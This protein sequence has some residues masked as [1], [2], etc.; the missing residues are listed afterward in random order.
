MATVQLELERIKIN[1]EKRRWQLYFVI[2]V[3][4]PSQPGTYLLTVL[5]KVGEDYIRLKPASNNEV[6]FEPQG[7][8]S[9][10]G[11]LLLESEVP[12][13][14]SLNVRFWLKHSRNNTRKVSDY[15]VDIKSKLGG[16]GLDILNTA[17]K[18]NNPWLVLTSAG[19]SIIGNILS[20][21]KD[22]DLGF[23]SMREVFDDNLID[24]TELDR[25]NNTTTNDATIVWSWSL[26]DHQ[27]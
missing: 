17:F 12:T 15:I 22:R 3:D 16:E 1:R 7:D 4:N 6:D 11:F 23:V 14:K 2:V 9:K 26:N 27:V 18:I 24:Q 19:L 8:G 13:N 21:V 25:W 5:P 10:A 20:K